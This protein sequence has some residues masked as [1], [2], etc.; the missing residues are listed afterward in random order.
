MQDIDK[1]KSEL[2]D[3][4]KQIRRH[5]KKYYEEDNPEISDYEY[6]QLMQRLKDIEAEYPELITSRSP[7]QLVGGKAKR[8]AGKLV[9]HDVPMLSL[10]D[11]FT[12]AEV[13]EFVNSMIEKLDNPEFVVEEKIDGLSLALR[14]VDGKLTQAITR[15]DGIIQ[16]EDVTENAK[17][18]DDVVDRLKNAPSYFEIRGEVYMTRKAFEAV[19]SRQ[20]LLGL[21]IFANPRN[22]AAGTLRQLDSRIVKERN[23]SMFVFNLQTAKSNETEINLFST[24]QPVF[25]THTDAYE[26]MKSNGIKVIHNYKICR[27]AEEVLAAI[28]D[29]GT[30]RGELEYDIDG[31]VV[32]INSF[33]Q[34]EELGAT[35]KFPRWAVAYKYPPEEKETILRKIE[36]S[37]G[38]TGRIN[39]TAVFDPVL[40]CGTKVERAT[41][42]NQDFIDELDIRIGDTITV[43]KSGEI[44]PKIKSVVKDKRSN[45][46]VPY[47]IGDTCPACGQKIEREE[48]AA[49][50]RCVNPNCP[51]QLESHIINFVGRTAMD[52][53]G[54]GATAIHNL[55]ERGYLKSIVDIYRLK[56]QREALVENAILGRDKN[57]DKVF[58]AIED[59]KNNDPAKLLTG[60]GIFGIGQAA[61]RDLIKNFGSID[62]I[63]AANDKELIAVPDLG[64]ISVKHIRSY[65]ND[66]ININLLSELK[67]LGLNFGSAE[68]R[69]QPVTHLNE[70][71][72]GKKFVLTGTLENFT[73]NEAKEL[74][75]ERGGKVS[76][77][78]SKNTDYVIA[79]ESA[80][81]KLQ[82][83]LEL[84]IKILNEDEFQALLN[85]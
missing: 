81:S 19:N 22:C 62:A 8:T 65:F 50:F 83:A 28:D 52:I 42:H 4:R 51:A 40:L 21:K 35:S 63:A 34:R 53:K 18:I 77:S 41:L 33:A 16:G 48:D 10:Q 30:S 73:R 14:Y 85:S 71:F 5:N 17:V 75:E 11:V 37:V 1:I 78:V 27:T 49:D 24:N 38:R 54:L 31:A 12:K 47:K 61:A 25:A 44:I 57:T 67:A 72:S 64:E 29:I 79:G 55:I 56:E 58:A 74:I 9:P 15:G 3:L 7:T 26:F 70:N 59:S 80:G 84:N 76:G 2:T 13:E 20:E 69:Q 43:Y 66:E 82:K 60:L 46:A 39:P 6:D 68:N 45:E 23:L 36:L 32:K